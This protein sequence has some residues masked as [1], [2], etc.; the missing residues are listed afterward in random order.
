M[1]K[2]QSSL[3]AEGIT[4]AHVL[5][6]DKPESERIYN[7]PYA[8]QLIIPVFYWIGRIF[9]NAEEHKSPGAIDFPVARCRYMDDVLK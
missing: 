3:T 5:E 2:N 8:R 7:D 6:V 9:T 1:K 4:I